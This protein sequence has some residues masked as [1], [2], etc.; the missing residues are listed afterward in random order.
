MRFWMNFGW[1]LG[2]F[3]EEFLEFFLGKIVK[4]SLQEMSKLRIPMRTARIRNLKFEKSCRIRSHETI[5][6]SSVAAGKQ[7]ESKRV[8]LSVH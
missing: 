6:I 7:K 3:W 4:M 5:G 8:K 1:I 2:G